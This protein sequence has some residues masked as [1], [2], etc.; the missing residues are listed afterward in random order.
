[1]Q[2]GESKWGK[3][4]IINRKIAFSIYQNLI[5]VLGEN[6][7]FC[8]LLKKC[9]EINSGNELNSVKLILTIFQ[10]LAW[11]HSADPMILSYWR[12]LNPR[13]RSHYNP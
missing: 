8:K 2:I 9:V 7:S 3:M 12:Q 13:H 5:G 11:Y 1:M 10:L 4:G 6:Q